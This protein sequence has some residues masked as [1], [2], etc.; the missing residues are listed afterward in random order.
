[1]QTWKAKR[2]FTPDEYIFLGKA[3]RPSM[4]FFCL[5]RQLVFRLLDSSFRLI[6]E[7]AEPTSRGCWGWFPVD[8]PYFLAGLLGDES[9]RCLSRH[10][11]DCRAAKQRRLLFSAVWQARHGRRYRRPVRTIM[12]HI[13]GP[14]AVFWDTS[15]AHIVLVAR[16]SVR[17]SLVR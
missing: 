13:L 10:L 7:A 15:H 8:S 1:M 9:S 6:L 14:M 17:R 12:I 11:T 3:T 2:L 5:P 16:E 4:L